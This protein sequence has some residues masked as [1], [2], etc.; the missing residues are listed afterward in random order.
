M[1]LARSKDGTPIAYWV[2]GAGPPL[3]LVHGTSTDHTRWGPSLGRLAQHFTVYAMDRR[4]RGHSGDGPAYAVEREYEDVAAVIQPAG[5][6]VD[7]L[8]HSFG[9]IC[10]LGAARMAPVR[11]L[12]LY[13]PPIP[14]GVR[15]AEDHVREKV[16]AQLAAGDH[17][18][19]I[20]TFLGEVLRVPLGILNAMPSS[21]AWPALVAAAPT[22]VREMD[23]E[24]RVH[25]EPA[26]FA[27]F[28]IPTLLLAGTDSPEFLKRATAAVHA[29]LP[30]SRLRELPGQAHAA[31]STAPDLFVREVRAFLEER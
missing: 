2:T 10:A 28:T 29:A 19:V 14:L 4:G 6:P 31:M 18:G 24:R 25:F 21:P 8:A 23:V 22:V 1:H 3:V 30:S 12:V 20:M 15:I 17:E 13:E 9:A 11:R 26:D 27:D 16:T 5:G 7:V